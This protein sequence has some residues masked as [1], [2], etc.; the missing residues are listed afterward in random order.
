MYDPRPT[1]ATLKDKKKVNQ[2]AQWVKAL[3]NKLD[4]CKFDPPVPQW[5]ERT[6]SHKL[7]PNLHT[8]TMSHTSYI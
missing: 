8:C 7:S 1:W 6:S 5:K 4:I 3:L 2:M